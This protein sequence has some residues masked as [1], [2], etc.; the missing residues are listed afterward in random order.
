MIHAILSILFRLF[1][2]ERKMYVG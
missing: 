2:L 1:S